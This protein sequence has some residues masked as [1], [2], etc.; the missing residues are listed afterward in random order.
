MIEIPTHL[1]DDA[2]TDA[3]KLLAAD[4]RTT[5]AA[6][7]AHLVEL[8]TRRLAV[9]AGYS[10]FT[11]CCEVLLLSEDAACNRTT[12]VRVVRA[13][14]GVLPML[15]DGRLNLS[16]LRVLA[17]HLSPGN[18]AE[19]LAEATYKSKRRV[20]ELVARRFPQP[21]TTSIRRMTPARGRPEQAIAPASSGVAPLDAAPP[22]S[23]NVGSSDCAAPPAG[24]TGAA[25]AAPPVKPSDGDAPRAVT[26]QAPHLAGKRAVTPMAEDVFLIRMA[27]SRAMVERLRRAQDL[28]A[29]AVAPGDVTEVFD[30]ALIALIAELEKRKFA[31]TDRPRRASRPAASASAEGSD[32]SPAGARN[33]QTR[34]IRAAVR[35]EVRARDGDQCAYVSPDGRRCDARAFLE[36]HHLRPYEVGGAGTADNISLR[37]QAHNQYEADVFF[38]P[39]RAALG[40]RAA[41]R[42]GADGRVSSEHAC[43]PAGVPSPP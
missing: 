1:T 42:P 36:F 12:A 34:L 8:D 16:T 33:K 20:E 32:S 21:V 25:E 35:R 37:C 14:P 41:I 19:L 24:S 26:A 15:A 11:Y 30:R 27:A 39:F 9:A 4:E 10:L 7:V 31:A 43:A 5:T 13:F 3:V 22:A 28:L 23:S 17:P 18:H 6:L 40:A 38:A 2:L 29:H